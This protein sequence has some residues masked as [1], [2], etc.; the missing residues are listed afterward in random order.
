MILCRSL[1]HSHVKNN[2]L[3][4]IRTARLSK[5]LDSKADHFPD[6]FRAVINSLLSPTKK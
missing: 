6:C 2:V 5:N 3:D 4:A 1:T